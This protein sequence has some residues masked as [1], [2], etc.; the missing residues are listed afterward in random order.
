MQDT[1]EI[2]A[3]IL[4]GGL[5]TR[6][7]SAVSDRPKVL[8]EVSGKPFLSYLLE[9]LSSAGFRRVVISTGYMAE[10][11]REAF[12]N[13]FGQLEILYSEEAE[14]L[15]S[16]GAL[17]LALGR[18][19]SETVLVMNGDSFIDADLAAY[20]N[21]FFEQERDGAML[22]TAVAETGRFGRVNIDGDKRIASFEEKS[23]IG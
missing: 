19:T 11:I 22:L 10:T 14:P 2:T 9:Q 3:I 23:N 13:I 1:S 16:G 17:R 21:W 15:G 12:G 20:V 6:L 7:R 5:G 4:A 8:A 18:S